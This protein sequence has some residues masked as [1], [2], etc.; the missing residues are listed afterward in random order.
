MPDCLVDDIAILLVPI[1]VLVALVM[2][3]ALGWSL[4][5]EGAHHR[6]R[7][8]CLSGSSRF[9][10]VM[11][12]QAWEIEK[13]GAIALSCHLLPRWYTSTPHH[14]G[15]EQGVQ[16]TLDRLHLEKIA[17][18]DELLII[19]VKGY[20]GESTRNEIAYAMALGKRVRFLSDR[21]RAHDA[22]DAVA[23]RFMEGRSRA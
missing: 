8:V 1:G 19:D 3:I 15:E 21:L 16:D 7:I 11:A 12:V 23:E 4:H 17:L 22:T 5:G 18:A 10:D 13:A 9:I 2:G 14:L 6:P 20:I